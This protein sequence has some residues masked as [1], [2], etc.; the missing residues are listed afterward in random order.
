[1]KRFE[2]KAALVTGAASG[3]GRATA[4]RLAA[5]GAN[6]A[7]GDINL[8]KAQE[9]A[10]A[11]AAA[12]GVK[13]HALQFDAADSAQCQTLV[14]QA[15]AAL[16]QLDVVVNNAGTMDW[17][18]AEEYADDAWD[19]V[20]KINLYSV[21]YVSRAAIPHLLKTKGAIVNMSSAASLQGGGVPFAAAYCASKAGINGLTRSM[22]VEYADKGLRVNTICP[23]GVDTR[24]NR[25]VVPLP[26]WL[27][28]TKIAS[29]FP[30]TGLMSDPAEIAGAVAYLASADAVNVTGITLSVDGGQT[31]G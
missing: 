22:A 26:K 11:I 17:S 15:V 8:E 23:G 24:L 25:D 27:D 4:E 16:G 5:E 10:T 2:G 31:A 19:R 18:R 29:L 13:T 1:M 20:L 12:H 21:F 9:A 7:L 3:I 28:M 6:V 30:K 14:E